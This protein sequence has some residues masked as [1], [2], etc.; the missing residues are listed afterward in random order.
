MIIRNLYKGLQIFVQIL[1]VDLLSHFMRLL[2][3]ITLVLFVVLHGSNG[4]IIFLSGRMDQYL[5]PYYQKILKKNYIKARGIRNIRVFV[6]KFN[7][8]LYLRNQ[9]SAKIFCWFSKSD[10][11]QRLVELMKMDAI[12]IMS[13]HY[14]Y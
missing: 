12:F 14:C 11:I 1:L 6:V 5:Y 13:C 10:L 8:L 4:I 9:H 3:T 2:Y 7:Q